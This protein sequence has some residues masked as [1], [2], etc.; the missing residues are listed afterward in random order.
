MSLYAARTGSSDHNLN[1]LITVVI[2]CQ[3]RSW[4]GETEQV[5]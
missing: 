2:G 3:S 5:E 1:R 4:D